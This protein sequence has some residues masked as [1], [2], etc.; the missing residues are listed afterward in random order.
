MNRLRIIPPVIFSHFILRSIAGNDSETRCQAKENSKSTDMISVYFTPDSKKLIKD[1]LKKKG[2]ENV[3]VDFACIHSRANTATEYVYKPLYGQRAAFRLKGWAK[4]NPG[5]MVGYGKVSC[6][7]GELKEEDFEISMP[8]RFGDESTLQEAVDLPT[9]LPKEAFTSGKWMGVIPATD[10]YPEVFL[11]YRAIPDDDQIVVDGYICGGKFVDNEGNCTFDKS[12][13]EF[14]KLEKDYEEPPT[15][16]KALPEETA[17]ETEKEC[18]VCKYMKAGPCR[19][20]FINWDKCVESMQDESE[21]RKCFPDTVHMM[22]CMRK[23]E[24]YDIMVA[25]TDP[26]KYEEAE[27]DVPE[28]K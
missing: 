16:V 6:M 2:L 4:T 24:Y 8:V 18:P 12:E 20:Q 21:L 14:K 22:R 25:G 27:Q 10:K 1:Y 26:K 5:Y 23:H 13:L 7:T 28:E 19:T 3:S 15:P 11:N 9:R 17:E